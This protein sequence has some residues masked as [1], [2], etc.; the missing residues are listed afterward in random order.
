MTN[1][2]ITVIIPS[3]LPSITIERMLNRFVSSAV[4][5]FD[6]QE[7]FSL[8]HVPEG[9]YSITY[10]GCPIDIKYEDRSSETTTIFFHASLGSKIRKLPVFSGSRFSE[11]ITSN[12][13]FI[14]D[15]TLNLYGDIRLSWYAGAEEI[16]NL[17]ATLSQVIKFITAG[18][19]R[20]YFG[21]SGGG[22]ASLVYSAMDSNSFAIS[23]NPQTNI[24]DYNPGPVAAWTNQAWGLTNSPRK[25]TAMP[26]VI[27][28]T[29][30]IYSEQI[31][32]HVA[33]VQN[34]NDTEHVISHYSPF[35]DRS[36]RNNHIIPIEIDGGAGHVPPSN[37]ILLSILKATIES[38]DWANLSEASFFEDQSECIVS[39]DGK[40]VLDKSLRFCINCDS[41]MDLQR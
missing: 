12:R 16:K 11:E 18:K 38:K 10:N 7:L 19:R 8:A 6:L 30:K 5:T 25:I 40:H 31:E 41:L 36:H 20:I 2:G 29:Q 23:V 1:P 21:A 3:Q 14:S 9:Q 22:F 17:Q 13:L 34:I 24:K 35:M 4:P 33:Y 27:T 37:D 39:N 26:P 28:N 15:P 32:N